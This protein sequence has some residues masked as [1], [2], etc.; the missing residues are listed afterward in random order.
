MNS[1]ADQTTVIF[2]VDGT[3]LQSMALEAE[4][5]IAT[6][7]KHFPMDEIDTDWANY[8]NT[9]DPGITMELYE[10]HYGRTPTSQELRS[11]HDLFVDQLSCVIARNSGQL[12]ETP[13]A[14]RL[15]AVL[16]EKPEFKVAIATGAWREPI[17]IKLAAAG[18][19]IEDFPLASADD[20]IDRVA[21]VS[22]AKR[23]VSQSSARCI[24][25]GDGVWDVVTARKMNVAFLGIGDGDQAERL[26]LAGAKHVVGDFQDLDAIFE[27]FEAAVVPEIMQGA[28]SARPYIKVGRPPTMKRRL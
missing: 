11:F 15:L 25:V 13:G 26:R 24:L 14:S 7:K 20:E 23:Y 19:D 2:D 8:K 10:R 9:T 18:L 27:L 21:I 28:C 22:H 16:R 5:Y 1:I 17:K 12:G 6:C 3:L 4:C